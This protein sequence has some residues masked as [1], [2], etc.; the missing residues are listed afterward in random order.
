MEALAASVP[1]LSTRIKSAVGHLGEDYPGY[2]PVGDTNTLAS[3]LQMAETD[4]GFYADLKKRSEKVKSL[5]DPAR[6][7]ESWKKLLKN[8]NTL[9]K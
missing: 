2:F 8:L 9:R 1:I 3:L 5:V 7:R 4:Q 6:E